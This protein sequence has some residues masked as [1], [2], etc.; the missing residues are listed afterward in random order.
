MAPKAPKVPTYYYY[1]G[2]AAIA[3]GYWLLQRSRAKSAAAAV[4]T[5]QAQSAA[6]LAAASPSPAAS[7]GN[8]GDLAAL[9]PYL[10]NL[11][12]QS[13][14]EPLNYAAPYGLKVKGQGYVG[15]PGDYL[16]SSSNGANYSQIATWQGRDQLIKAGQGANV[17]YQPAPGIFVPWSEALRGSGTPSYLKV[18]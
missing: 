7:Y 2:A 10:T 16:A 14:A 5:A 6:D 4:T 11:Q 13:T 15:A 1:V 9:A 3:A 12:G 17:F 18:A 8:A